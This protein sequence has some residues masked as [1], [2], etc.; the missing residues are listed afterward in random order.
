MKNLVLLISFLVISSVGYAQA[1]M[2]IKK[3]PFS[4]SAIFQNGSKISLNEAKEIAKTNQEIV[5]KL[6]AAQFNRTLGGII[7]LPGGFAFGYTI[8]SSLGGEYSTV[9]P[10][11]TVGGIGAAMMVIGTIMQFKGDKQ[12][13][14]AVSEYNTSFE[15]TT[16]LFHPEFYMVSSENGIGMSM[17]F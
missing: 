3:V 9:K 11:W 17:R 6:N 7:G 16:A 12:L 5:K 8:G 13:K 10:N 2:S 4:G 14:E 1:P 15:N